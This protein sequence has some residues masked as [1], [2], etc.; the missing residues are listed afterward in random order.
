MKHSAVKI[1]LSLAIPL[2]ALSFALAAPTANAQQVNSE[3]LAKCSSIENALKRL[4]CY[5]EVVEGSGMATAAASTPASRPASTPATEQ[6]AASQP[7]DPERDFGKPKRS[8]EIDVLA[9]QI[10]SKRKNAYGKWVIT[11]TNGQRW[12]QTDSETFMLPDDGKYQ[13]ERGVFDSFF[14]ARE[15]LSKRIKVRRID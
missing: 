1:L 7:S 13:I 12:E 8:D 5:D 11:L 2:S 10:E 9:V 6:S 3:E 15:G 14:L 4:V